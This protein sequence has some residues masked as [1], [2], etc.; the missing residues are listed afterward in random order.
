MVQQPLFYYVAPVNGDDE[1]YSC[2]SNTLILGDSRPLPWSE[3][4]PKQVTENGQWFRSQTMGATWYIR[5]KG[6]EPLTD[7]VDGS[8]VVTCEPNRD[9]AFGMGGFISPRLD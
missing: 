7:G 9:V 6:Y 5:Y 2:E 3:T 1:G 8:G 4:W